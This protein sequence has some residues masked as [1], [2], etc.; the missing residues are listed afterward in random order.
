[1]TYQEAIKQSTK[2]TAIRKQKSANGLFDETF[3]VYDDY[4]CYKLVAEQGKV[5]FNLSKPVNATER[6]KY[7]DWQP[8]K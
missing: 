6:D 5:V 8:N 1:M 7:T 3:I 2:R 4:S